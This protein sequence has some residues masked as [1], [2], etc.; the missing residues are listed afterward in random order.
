LLTDVILP[1]GMN[2]QEIADEF[3][4]RYPSAGILYSSGYTRE[5]LSQRSG[6]AD[7]VELLHKPFQ[8]K[9]LAQRVRKILNDR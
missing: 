2:G 6:I 9:T 5:V 1:H 7:D 3:H 8:A 4:E